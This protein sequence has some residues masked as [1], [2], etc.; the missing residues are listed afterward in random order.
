MVNILCI[1]SE[2]KDSRIAACEAGIARI[3]N[4]LQGSPDEWEESVDLARSI[5]SSLDLIDFMSD[6]EPKA[7]QVWTVD[8]IQK[9]AYQDADSGGIPDL[10]GWCQTQWLK[11]LAIYREDADV[12]QGLS[13]FYRF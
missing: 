8:T 13:F 1:M 5:T 2:M 7:I 10:A 11:L 12:L 3:Y 9:L 4:M 6:P